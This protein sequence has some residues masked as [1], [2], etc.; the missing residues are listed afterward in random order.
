M[1]TDS[2]IHNLFVAESGVSCAVYHADLG[3]KIRRE[4]HQRFV[5]DL[6]PVVVATVAFGMGIDKPGQVTLDE[7]YL[8]HSNTYI[9]SIDCNHCR[10]KYIQNRVLW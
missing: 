8:F 10:Y 1:A 9:E 6:V 2:S 7:C 3:L 5:R 4:V